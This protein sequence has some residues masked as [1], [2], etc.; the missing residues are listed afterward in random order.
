MVVRSR[1]ARPPRRRRA[2]GLGAHLAGA[3]PPAP[4]RPHRPT[5]DPGRVPRHVRRRARRRPWPT[6]QGGRRRPRQHGR[7]R[8]RPRRRRRHRRSG[9]A[10]G[11]VPPPPAVDPLLGDAER[12]V[13][14][15]EGSDERAALVHRLFLAVRHDAGRSCHR[16]RGDLRATTSHH[17]RAGSPRSSPPTTAACALDSHAHGL[18]E[19]EFPV[20]PAEYR[21]R[22]LWTRVRS[23]DDV[24]AC[25]GPRRCRPAASAAAARRPRRRRLHR[26]RRQPDRPAVLRSSR[27]SPRAVE[28][29]AGAP[30]LLRPL[31]PRGPADRRARRHRDIDPARSGFGH[32]RRHRPAPP[33]RPRRRAR[34][35]GTRRLG[36]RARRRPA[37]GRR[38]VADALHAAGRTGRTAFWV[39][40]R[41]RLLAALD[42]WIAFDRGAGRAGSCGRRS[43]FGDD[44]PV[45]LVLPD[46]RASGSAGRST[47]STS[48][49][50]ARSW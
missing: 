7:R 43:G 16:P 33:R 11:L 26:V 44:P 6:R 15:L 49:P 5:G 9:A 24:R 46:G 29:W 41:A 31:R 45:A 19:T 22:E 20:S 27:P 18:A 48:C 40:A 50:T 30:R 34:S 37:P 13:A 28:T 38:A 23:G 36:R 3:R 4:P 21:L 10:D 8:G 12:A 32:P 47:A 39:N 35:P 2:A 42:T 14:G 1:A 17:L 25:R